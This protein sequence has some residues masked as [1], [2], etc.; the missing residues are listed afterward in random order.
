MALRRDW[1]ASPNHSGRS[2]GA[3]R[4]IVIHTAEGAL[5]Y[6]AL[7]NYF[8]NPAS[9]VS[10]HTG[11]DDTPGVIGEY[12][13]PDRSA[14]TAGSVNGYSV[15]TELCAFAGWSAAE[16]DRHP[17]MLEN[18]AQWVA[19]EAARYGIPLVRSSSNGVCGHVD[20]PGD[21]WDPGPNFPYDRVIS[22]AAG[23]APAQPTKRKGHNMIASTSTGK[24]YWT[25]TTDGAV[26]A[27]G[28]AQYEEGAFSPDVIPPGAEIVGIAGCGTD[29][30]W[31]K[32]SDGSIYS[33]GSAEYH[34]RPDRG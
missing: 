18:C 11:I 26:G 25:V 31:L 17:V 6:K 24:G 34:G 3:V 21:H 33:F 15:Q 9:E 23:G 7:G 4:L 16:W 1:I 29:G 13:K 10:S 30:Y 22:M 20:V 19:E 27:F 5:T 14:W 12:V 2:G 28:D 32:G 8:A